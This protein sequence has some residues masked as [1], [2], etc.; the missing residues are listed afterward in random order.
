MTEK[1]W[2]WNSLRQS[3]Q[4]RPLSRHPTEVKAEAR[5]QSE[6]GAF[7]AEGTAH[8]KASK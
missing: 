6:V 1:G 5:S 2:P 8:A 7:Q 4:R 3:N